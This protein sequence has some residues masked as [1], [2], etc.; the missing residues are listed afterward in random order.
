MLHFYWLSRLDTAHVAELFYYLF[1]MRRI[2][3]LQSLRGCNELSRLV[4]IRL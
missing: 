3:F 4:M 2:D 1:Q